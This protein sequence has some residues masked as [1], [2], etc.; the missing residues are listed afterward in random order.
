M[1]KAIHVYPHQGYVDLG[2]FMCANSYAQDIENIPANLVVR[3]GKL[4]LT[5]VQGLNGNEWNRAEK[6]TIATLLLKSDNVVIFSHLGS[7]AKV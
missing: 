3:S 5:L 6:V 2:H 1:S 7:C 4:M